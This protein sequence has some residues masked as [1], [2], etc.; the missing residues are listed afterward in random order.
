MLSTVLPQCRAVL[1]G[2]FLVGLAR[3]DDFLPRAQ[4]VTTG[5]I[6]DGAVSNRSF[7]LVDCRKICKRRKK[8]K[9]Y[10]DDERK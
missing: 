10:C 8:N 6:F 2:V 7:G 4:D 5:W 9:R 1:F 3:I